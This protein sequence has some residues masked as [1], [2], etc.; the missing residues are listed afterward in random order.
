MLKKIII[1]LCILFLTTLSTQAQRIN[2]AFTIDNNYPIFTLLAIE[3]ILKNNTSNSDYTF[4]IVE[5]NI[6]KKNKAKM[7]HHVTDKWGQQIE[8][9]N[10]NTESIDKGINFYAF[11]HSRI[12][13]IGLARITIPNIIPQN[14]DRIIYLDGDILVTDD[15][16]ELYNFD[17]QNKP[18]G[19]VKNIVKEKYTIHKFKNYYNSGVILLD[20]KKWRQN[21]ITEAMLN[22]LHSHSQDFMYDMDSPKGSKYRYGDQD[23]INCV[24]ENNI[25]TLP[26]KWNNQYIRNNRNL[27][28]DN[29]G[30]YHY[31]GSRKPWDFDKLV[32][33]KAEKKYLYYWDKSDLRVYK[34]Y[35]KIIAQIKKIKKITMHKIF[36]YLDYF[37]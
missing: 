15:L 3:S 22:Y 32:K 23:L 37:S 20:T 1:I 21:H 24:L 30:I 31:I 4:Y 7:K 6:T 25:T 27:N 16:L 9:I 13:P 14:I 33:T 10:I 17:L 19:L 26:Q 11:Q 34:Y 28:Q 8:F 12:T 36:R 2:V 29:S 35:Y 18:A 5:N